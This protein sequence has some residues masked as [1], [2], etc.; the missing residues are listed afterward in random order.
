MANRRQTLPFNDRWYFHRGPLSEDILGWGNRA[1]NAGEVRLLQKSGNHGL[2]KVACE[3]VKSWRVVDLPHDFVIE[4]PFTPEASVHNGSLKGDLGHY[5]KHFELAPEDRSGRIYL[6]FDGAF[7]DSEVHVNGQYQGRHRSGYTGFFFDIT[8]ACVF[9]KPNAVSVSVDA[10]MNELWSYEGGGIYRGVRLVK[11]PHMH[12]KPW[13]VFITAPDREHP[14]KW[15]ANIQVVNGRHEPSSGRV[16]LEWI[17]PQGKSVF[18]SAKTTVETGAYGETAA[19]IQGEIPSPRLWSPKQ[20]HLYRCRISVEGPGG[21]VDSVEQTFGFRHFHFDA[22]KGFFLNGEGMKLKGV[23]CHQ[24]HGGV[25]VAVSPAL[26]EWRVLKLK[27]MG[28]NALRTS[29]NPPDPALLDACDRHGI[30]V[31]D[32]I[33]MPGGAAELLQDLKDLLL[34]DRNHPSVILWSIGNEEMNIQNTDSGIAI[35]R[36]MQALVHELDPTR[37]TTY[38]MNCDWMNISKKHDAADFRFDVFG[39]NYRNDQNS[40]RYDEFHRTFPDWPLVGSETWGGTATRGLY[41]PD[42]HSM[43]APII[44]LRRDNPKCWLDEKHKH[45]ASAYGNFVTPW[46]YTIEETWRDCADRPHLAGTFLWTGF[47]YRGETTPYE[48][49]AVVTRF[50]ILDLCGF[51]KEVAHYLTAWWRPETP[52][53]FLMPHWDWQGKEGESIDVWCYGNTEEVELSLNGKS[54]GRKAMPRNGRLEWAVPYAPGVLEAQGFDSKGL[55]VLSTRRVTTTGPGAI[56]L[57]QDLGALPEPDGKSSL[58]ILQAAIV[59][60]QGVICPRAANEVTFAVEGPG[61]IIG[62]G[63]GNPMSH[64]PDQGTN[65]RQ[66]Y[67]GLCQVMLR[68][69]GPVTVTATAWN[70]KSAKFSP[71][72]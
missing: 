17:D 2:S 48:Y 44:P 29:H 39:A 68:I 64:E 57:S 67:H 52:H 40:E 34:R 63:N 56:A 38:A 69:R 31:M 71:V 12:L 53:L 23:C 3:A 65:R 51:K 13:G 25:G 22:A 5:V 9:D 26:Q 72:L 28:V 7:R 41:E 37:P 18:A 43:G 62:V 1:F 59:D 61:E 21:L 30:L 54:L 10:R 60:R 66:A 50:G 46:G 33:R 11:V 15:S 6:E 45:F 20:P 49:P 14:G 19:V 32:E 27:E 70:L 24:D 35:F 55:K 16:H 36:R 47:D 8:E 58:V 42:H 4:G